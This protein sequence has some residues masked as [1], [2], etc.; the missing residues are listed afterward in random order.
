MYYY[1]ITHSTTHSIFPQVPRAFRFHR[2]N[3][4]GPHGTCTHSGLH[5]RKR[6][7]SQWPQKQQ[8][9]ESPF[10]FFPPREGV[11]I[12]SSHCGHL[13]LVV[14]SVTSYRTV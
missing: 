5:H 12:P 6:T 13:D 9:A 14:T 2:D 1:Y 3:A 8:E 4:V 11:V 10:L 7:Q